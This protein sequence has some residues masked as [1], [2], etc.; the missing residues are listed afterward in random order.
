MKRI[1][2]LTLTF[3]MILAMVFVVSCKEDETQEGEKTFKFIAVGADGA[4]KEWT[5]TT[6]ETIVAKALINEG[7]VEGEDGPYGLYVTSVNGEYHKFEDDGKYWAFYIVGQY[8]NTGV[9]KTYIKDG[10]TYSFKAE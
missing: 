1:L 2:S 4:E 8:A 7:L 5:I 6:E 3:L 9:E 10:A